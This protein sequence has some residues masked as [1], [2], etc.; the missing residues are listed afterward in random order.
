[1]SIA[2]LRPPPLESRPWDRIT[3]LMRRDFLNWGEHYRVQDELELRSC[4]LELLAMN[5]QFHQYYG[6]ML[7]SRFQG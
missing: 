3:S 6:D 5:S 2:I 1:M 4:G 7:R